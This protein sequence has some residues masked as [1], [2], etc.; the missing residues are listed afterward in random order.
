MRRAHVMPAGAWPGKMGLSSRKLSHLDRNISEL[1]NAD[2]GG[3]WTTT[4]PICIGGKGMTLNASSTIDGG[5]TTRPGYGANDPKIELVDQWPTFSSRT[6]S[7]SF[8]WSEGGA[9]GV[10]PIA[11]NVKGSQL[12]NGQTLS[13]IVDGHRMHD[14]AT[15]TKATF[16][17]RYTGAKP[18]VTNT[19]TAAIIRRT[20][21]NIPDVT[22]YMHTNVT[23][24]GVVY[25]NATA[26]RDH[27]G[28]T[29]VF[30]NGGNV[31]NLE[32]VPN[33]NNVIDKT[34]A[35]EFRLILG[36]PT[37]V[38]AVKLDY[39]ITSQRFE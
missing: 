36:L 22:G 29:D 39:T 7:K 37:E 26:T 12:P 38:F 3:L 14:G 16:S 31:I 10:A 35:Y 4:G 19:E 5:I 8:A 34:Y 23:S 33:Q 2:D 30:H 18:L 24:G 9:A 27:G 21:A 11:T 17:Y 6:V 25:F 1:V 15:L 13:V 28:S 32:Y 20:T